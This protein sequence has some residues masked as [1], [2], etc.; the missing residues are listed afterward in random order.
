MEL[1]FSRDLRVDESESTR[2][3]GSSALLIINATFWTGPEMVSMSE[4]APLAASRSVST[5][6]RSRVSGSSS[7]GPTATDGGKGEGWSFLPS[8]I[9]C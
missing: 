2:L 1:N 8:Q 7:V 5:V 4:T 6:V 3:I 9:A